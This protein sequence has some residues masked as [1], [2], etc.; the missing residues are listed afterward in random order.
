MTINSVKSHINLD[1][2]SESNFVLSY[3]CNIF[4]NVNI[5]LDLSKSIDTLDHQ[6]FIK[7]LEYYGWNALSIKLKESYLSNWKQNVEIDNSESDMLDLTSEGT[8]GIHSGSSVIH[9]LH[10]WH[11]S[12][13]QIVWFYY[14]CRWY[15]P[16][17][18]YKIVVRTTAN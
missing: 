12:G 9:Y 18:Y 17:Y 1:L 2:C 8:I 16:L 3:L 7:K 5:F 11:S 10:E 6:I 4:I 15:Y 14:I 13:I